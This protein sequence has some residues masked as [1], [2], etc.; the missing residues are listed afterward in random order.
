MMLHNFNILNVTHKN[1]GKYR[2]WLNKTRNLINMQNKNSFAQ[3][4][5]KFS[6]SY[7]LPSLKKKVI[8]EQ[9]IKLKNICS[10]MRK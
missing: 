7:R 1:Q 9:N 3:R 10:N 2:C 4:K 6:L 5:T 8:I